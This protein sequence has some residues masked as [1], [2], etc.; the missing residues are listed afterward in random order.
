MD[1]GKKMNPFKWDKNRLGQLGCP[2]FSHKKKKKKKQK[3]NKMYLPFG[4]SCSKL[5][6]IKCITLNSLLISRM[7]LV[8]Q[9]NT[10]S[11]ILKLYKSQHY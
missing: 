2:Y 3:Q 10:C 1:L 7:S 4:K 6:D 5:L 9:I 8:K 11:I